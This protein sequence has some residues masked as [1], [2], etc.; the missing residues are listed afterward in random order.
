M[1]GYGVRAA[2]VVP[3]ISFPSNLHKCYEMEKH[4]RKTK[5][6]IVPIDDVVHLSYPLS[7]LIIIEATSSIQERTNLYAV[8]T[9]T[10]VFVLT[11]LWFAKRFFDEFAPLAVC[12]PFNLVSHILPLSH[13]LMNRYNTK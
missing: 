6:V 11:I 1:Y 5:T 4:A 3:T 10:A 8:W 12:I 9:G 13:F 7:G 2:M